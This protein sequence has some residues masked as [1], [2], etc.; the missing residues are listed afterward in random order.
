MEHLQQLHLILLEWQLQKRG[1]PFVEVLEAVDE[2]VV[3]MQIVID[4]CCEIGLPDAVEDID[5]QFVLG[6]LLGLLTGEATV[7]GQTHQGVVVRSFHPILGAP[8]EH[9]VVVE[10]VHRLD[11]NSASLHRNK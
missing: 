10:D 1:E 7:M 9:H 3:C 11:H 8:A 5:D 4:F 2:V 6:V